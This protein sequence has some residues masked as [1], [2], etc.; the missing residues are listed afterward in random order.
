MARAETS[1]RITD[2][3][4]GLYSNSESQRP[5]E[6]IEQ[7]QEDLWTWWAEADLRPSPIRLFIRDNGLKDKYG[8]D[9]VSQSEAASVIRKGRVEQD[10]VEAEVAGVKQLRDLLISGEAKDGVIYLSPP[11]LRRE[12][13]DGRRISFTYLYHVGNAGRIHFLAVPEL[14]VPVLE[15]FDRVFDLID[16][17]STAVIA[18]VKVGELS[19]R[20]LVAYPFLAS[21]SNSLDELSQKLG[22]KNL[23][24]LWKQALEAKKLRGSVGEIITHASQ[25]IWGAHQKKDKLK[26]EVL[27]DV[28]RGVVALMT[29]TGMD[30]VSDPVD[31]FD[32]KVEAIMSAKKL[33][34]LGGT[35]QSIYLPHL[36]QIYEFQMRMN[37]NPYAQEV[38]SGGSCPTADKG[39]D[40]GTRSLFGGEDPWRQNH[41]MMDLF[42]PGNEAF[43]G[44]DVN[45]S[46]STGKYTEFYDY[47]PGICKHC[48]KEKP[49]VAH[50]KSS[51]V[52][53]AGWCSDC[54]K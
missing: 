18:G 13:F 54:E 37:S 45:Y 4:A 34:R 31:Y 15:H 27:S 52:K 8:N 10:R 41:T 30:D 19:D 32:N 21:D 16:Q 49:H 47:K 17:G 33:D 7:I 39:L 48:G 51:E 50:P 23:L 25:E 2:F 42:G 14:E 20:K 53:C 40:F 11:G 6:S 43:S 26:L 9:L 38:T 3:S 36:S 44:S 35:T 28:F 22:Y 29:G 46:S 1:E 12:G 24:D 5:I